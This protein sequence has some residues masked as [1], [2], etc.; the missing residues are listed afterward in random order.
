MPNYESIARLDGW[1]NIGA[2]NQANWLRMLDVIDAAHLGT[3]TRFTTNQDRMVH[4]VELVSELGLVF[5]TRTTDDWMQVLNDAALPAG[6]ILDIRQMHA[7]PQAQARQMVVDV[8][9]SKAGKM[10]TLGAPVKFHGTPGGVKRAAPLL[11]QHSAEVLLEAGYSG[12]D[13][14]RLTDAGVL[15]QVAVNKNS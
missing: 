2:A 14:Q 11:G 3:D 8:E 5:S 13:I 4:R 9:H 6:P 1:V 7:D 10:K 15:G 12:A